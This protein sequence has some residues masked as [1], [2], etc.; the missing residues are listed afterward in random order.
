MAW[1]NTDWNIASMFNSPTIGGSTN[2]PYGFTGGQ[3][4]GNMIVPWTNTQTGET[5]DA[6]N[7]GYQPPNSNW[8]MTGGNK[9]NNLGSQNSVWGAPAYYQKPSNMLSN[10]P[11]QTQDGGFYNPNIFGQ[12][13]YPSQYNT[14][15]Q[16]WWMNNTNNSIVNNSL[17]SNMPSNPM[18]QG[19]YIGN[20]NHG[21]SE[22][23]TGPV[24]ATA[25]AAIEAGD[26]WSGYRRDHQQWR[27]NEGIY[28]GGKGKQPGQSDLHYPGNKDLGI[29]SDAHQLNAMGMG[30]MF[31]SQ[32]P[33]SEQRKLLSMF[34]ATP[35]AEGGN[36]YKVIGDGTVVLPSGLT[37]ET[38]L[39]D[40]YEN[41]PNI[42]DNE[43]E[44][45]AANDILSSGDLRRF[46]GTE[47]IYPLDNS[48]A[49][50][51]EEDIDSGMGID[52][53]DNIFRLK[54][55]ELE[56]YD[57]PEGRKLFKERWDFEN[58]FGETDHWNLGR[59]GDSN[60]VPFVPTYKEPEP[61]IQ[62]GE[63]NYFDPGENI[64][65]K[66]AADWAKE[67][68]TDRVYQHKPAVNLDP[69]NEASNYNYQSAAQIAAAE[70]E[71]AAIAAAEEEERQRK[72]GLAEAAQIKAKE[73]AE[74]RARIAAAEAAAEKARQ[75]AAAQK[76]MNDEY[77]TG[78]VAPNIF[79]T[80]GPSKRGSRGNRTKPEPPNFRWG[81][82]AW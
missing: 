44:L 31:E 9:T 37:V 41:N 71:V 63:Y 52:T 69:F 1:F 53:L 33:T 48:D 28:A 73:A 54:Q 50:F 2:N 32:L 79:T 57:G 7:T 64:F 65:Q 26:Y 46:F 19:K 42:F 62:S 47:Q 12:V 24:Y 15:E 3:A 55:R 66:T 17:T 4:G 14:N 39:T 81:R 58:P 38:Q 5:W 80:S 40:P 82:K 74:T 77:D 75:A 78:Y 6:P 34:S 27:D 70:A 29:R 56:K 20:P 45:R 72:I 11:Y 23:E 76:R 49:I 36:D 51:K 21:G 68:E 43:N 13:N 8:Q 16:P 60:Y 67:Y 61:I 22:Y 59:P 10:S 25:D 18:D 35:N 30:G